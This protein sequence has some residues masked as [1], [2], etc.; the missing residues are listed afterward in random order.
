MAFLAKARSVKE[1]AEFVQAGVLGDETVQLTGVASVEAAASGDLIFVDQEK[2]FRRAVESHAS[3]VIVGDFAADAKNSKPLLVATQPRLA[4]ARAAQFL[5]PRPEPK[6]GIHPSAIVHPSARLAD[7]VTVEARV[8]VGEGVQIEERT[9]VGSGC[10][11]G[12]NA[13]IGCNCDLYPNITV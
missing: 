4:F 6:P 3:A 5:C 12:A 10:V 2:N 11:I 7:S 9:W 1:V 8:V 13:S